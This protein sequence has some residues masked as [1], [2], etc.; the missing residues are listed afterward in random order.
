MSLRAFCSLN[1]KLS[2]FYRIDSSNKSIFYINT[3]FLS[4]FELS[5]TINDFNFTI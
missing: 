5:N 3:P 2:I 4:T 1:L